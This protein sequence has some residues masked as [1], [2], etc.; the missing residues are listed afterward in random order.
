MKS[1]EDIQCSLMDGRV[2]CCCGNAIGKIVAAAETVH[3]G[4]QMLV[5]G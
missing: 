5:G 1:E 3:L 2:R 4:Q